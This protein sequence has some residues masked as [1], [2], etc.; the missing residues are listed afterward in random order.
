MVINATSTFALYCQRCSKIQMHDISHFSINKKVREL[1]CSCNHIQAKISRLGSRQLL[2]SIPCVV[3][4]STHHI[5]IELKKLLH[6]KLD[7]VYCCKD[8]FELGYLGD[9]KAINETLADQKRECE[10]LIRETDSTYFEEYPGKHHIILDVLN[11][12][13]DIA[14]LGGVYCRCG[15]EKVEADIVADCIVLECL[16]C[17]GYYVMSAQTEQDVVH[18]QSLT[19]IELEPQ[20]CF[21]K[22]D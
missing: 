3:C 6:T 20:R 11:K 12:V 9:R 7:K 2:L 16:Q 4:Q 1:K 17:G 21:A 5:Y 13:H 8:N 15:S 14:E 10:N 18:A 19:S 22:K